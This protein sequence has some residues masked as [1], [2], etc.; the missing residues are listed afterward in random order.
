[1][2]SALRADLHKIVSYLGALTTKLTCQASA[3][4]QIQQLNNNNKH[5]TN[6]NSKSLPPPCNYLQ[7]SPLS[8]SPTP[9]SSSLSSTIR[10]RAAVGEVPFVPV[11]REHI[12][13]PISVDDNMNLRC[14]VLAPTGQQ[15]AP[16]LH[17]ML[18]GGPIIIRSSDSIG[19]GS[20][21]RLARPIRSTTE[22][23]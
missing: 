10:G 4:S 1:M 6:S 16:Q 2:K 20:F 14:N 7:T 22:R 17:S 15:Q 11:Q 9:V 13:P 23:I 8:S 3:Q 5:R 19:M 12:Q 21:R 18:P